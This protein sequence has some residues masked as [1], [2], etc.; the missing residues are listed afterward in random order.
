MLLPHCSR[1]H[2]AGSIITLAQGSSCA[3]GM[4]QTCLHALLFKNKSL[5]LLFLPGFSLKSIY[6]SSCL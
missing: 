6:S 5:M 4:P 3:S 2:K 1:Q